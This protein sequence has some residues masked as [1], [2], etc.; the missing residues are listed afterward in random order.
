M[1]SLLILIQKGVEKLDFPDSFACCTLIDMIGI[2]E[3]FN[4]RLTNAIN[5]VVQP[6]VPGQSGS[7]LAV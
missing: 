4:N 3:A 5:K 2:E 7:T 6:M 1:H